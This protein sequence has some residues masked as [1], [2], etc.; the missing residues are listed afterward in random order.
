MPV[1]T[2]EFEA[3]NP[4]LAEMV[5]TATQIS[6]PGHGILATDEST[7]TAGKRL[8]S[9]GLTNTE[10]NRKDFRE[11]L[12][13]TPGLGDHISGCILFDE[14]MYQSTNSGV[15]F[16]QLLRD[17]GIHV[18]MKVDTGL[19][20]LAGTADE[21][22]TQGLDGLGERC[23]AYYAEG[24]RFAKWRAAFKVDERLGLPSERAIVE[25]SRSLAR[26]ASICQEHG[27]VPIVEP[28]VTLGPG[29]Y[30][31]ETAAYQNERVLSHVM[32]ELNLHDVILE[33]V[34][35]KPSMV[36]PG[37]DNVVTKEEVAKYTARTLLR[38]VPPAVVGVH[39]L[40]GGMGAEEATQNL[41]QLQREAPHAPWA[42]SFS[43][44]RAL[45]DPVLK[46]WAGSADN[47]G[48]AQALMYELCR[49]NGEAT[50]GVWDEQHP[51]TGGGRV[52]LPKL[53][54]AS[55]RVK[56]GDIFNW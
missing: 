4:Y 22:A 39:F 9:I 1:M 55:E 52:S 6:R 51:A 14:T 29:D 27:L 5:E 30:S 8:L 33:A 53:S 42:L 45:Q 23:K 25:N 10:Q 19:Q 35:F 38:T 13:T 16:V 41:Q 37:L 44:G 46:E 43:F 17:Q 34:L 36:L 48:A 15:R 20:R 28:E 21:T 12:Y 56:D 40:S 18:G 50:L 49:V 7:V 11:L 31:I 24:A 3:H 32:R 2:S 26:Y 47:V 54:L